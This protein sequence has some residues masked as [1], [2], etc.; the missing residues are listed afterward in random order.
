[1]E[2]PQEFSP[3]YLYKKLQEKRALERHAIG[4]EREKRETENFF[5]EAE[6]LANQLEEAIQNLDVK[7]EDFKEKLGAKDRGLEEKILELQM[8]TI[9][10]EIAR[11]ASPDEINELIAGSR[12]RL[13]L[14][15]R[16]NRKVGNL[17]GK[18]EEKLETVEE[19]IFKKA[20]SEFSQYTYRRLQELREKIEKGKNYLEEELSEQSPEAFMAHWLLRLREYQKQLPSGIVETPYVIKQKE[21]AIN[22]LLKNKLIALVGE[23]GTGK[24]RIARKIAEELTGDYEFIAGHSFMTKED[25]FAYLGISVKETAAEDVP[26]LI[27]EAKKRYFSKNPEALSLSE[28]ERTK[29]ER[30]I[31][32]TVRE[33][34]AQKEMVS[35]VFLAGVLKA[36]KE[37]KIVIIDEFNYIP[38]NLLAGINA[39]IE[40]KPGERINIFG[41]EIKV[42]PGFGVIFTGNIT[43][44]E[45]RGRYLERKAV[46]PALVNRLNSGLIEYASLPQIE[47]VSFEESILERQDIEK[48]KTPFKRELFIIGLAELVDKKGNLTGPTNLLNKLW[49]LCSNFS[50][51]QKLYA[52]EKLETPIKLP[53]G[54]D[55]QLR[56]YHASNRTFRSI[57]EG[58]KKEGFTLPVDWYIYDNL[59]RPASIIAPQEASQIFILLKERGGFFRDPCWEKI[60]VDLSTWRI[61]GIEDIEKDRGNFIKSLKEKGG[62][63]RF[64]TPQEI[65]E[66]VSGKRMPPFPKEIIK[67]KEVVEIDRELSSILTEAE[68]LISSWEEIIKIYCE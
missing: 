55:F 28:E 32:E 39:L 12:K 37:G 20:V 15:M 60:S 68:N 19:E 16:K 59:I 42:K 43:Q 5:N 58:W 22:T 25:L 11:V 23:T 7:E 24:T 6:E 13:V 65:A 10:E 31:E 52:G 61:T 57:L 26:V 67:R 41:T 44:T 2:K 46:D 35:E 51:L 18:L 62:E 14:F 63:I 64:F 17:I 66:A 48:G 3:E 8:K 54:A 47:T 53:T 30:W 38:P 45:F 4:I 36:A 56:I 40:A 50:L 21:R 34:A 29:I 27:E 9:K 49:D 1:M 33:K